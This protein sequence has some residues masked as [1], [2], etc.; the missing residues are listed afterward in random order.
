VPS[1]P[2]IEKTV[3][4]G[5]PLWKRGIE[6]DFQITGDQKLQNKADAGLFLK[7]AYP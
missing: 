5:L 1:N 2:I 3:P 6:G 7:I 4:P